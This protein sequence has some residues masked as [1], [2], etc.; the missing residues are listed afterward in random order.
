MGRKTSPCGSHVHT[1]TPAARDYAT[2]EKEIKGSPHWEGCQHMEKFMHLLHPCGCHV[3]TCIPVVRDC[4][5]ESQKDSF[6]SKRF[7]I[8]GMMGGKVKKELTL[9]KARSRQTLEDSQACWP[10]NWSRIVNQSVGVCQM[11]AARGCQVSG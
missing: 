8:C 5:R 3:Y 11:T 10:N 4:A 1:R 6:E 2:K 9:P 7:F